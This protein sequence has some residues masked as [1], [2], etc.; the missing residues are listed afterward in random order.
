MSVLSYVASLYN[1]L[2]YVAPVLLPAELLVRELCRIKLGW[3]NDVNNAIGKRWIEWVEQFRG[4]GNVCI[5]RCMVPL[6]AGTGRQ[7]Q[8]HAFSDASL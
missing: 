1:P 8:L 2:G 7:Y 3:D 5:D 6:E 4:L